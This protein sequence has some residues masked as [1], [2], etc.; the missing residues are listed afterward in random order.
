MKTSPLFEIKGFDIKVENFN[1]DLLLNWA[2][3]STKEFGMGYLWY[4]MFPSP[5]TKKVC[6]TLGPKLSPGTS[7]EIRIVQ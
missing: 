5:G 6:G 2:V 3:A 4:L 7:L 1:Y